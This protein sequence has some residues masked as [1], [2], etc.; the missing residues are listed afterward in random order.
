MNTHAARCIF[1]LASTSTVLVARSEP[2]PTPTQTRPSPSPA[3]PFNSLR[4][5]W[6][7]STFADARHFR[8]K[9]APSRCTSTPPCL[10]YPSLTIGLE[11]RVSDEHTLR[12]L[13]S[14]AKAANEKNDRVEMGKLAHEMGAIAY[15]RN[16]T[17]NAR[18]AHLEKFGCVEYTKES[19][20]VIKSYGKTRGVIEMGAGNGQWSRKLRE[21]GLDIVSF[22]NMSGLPL[23]L[24]LYHNR[25][26]PN[27]DFFDQQLRKADESILR[28]KVKLISISI[29]TN[30]NNKANTLTP[31]T[32]RTDGP[33]RQ[34]STTYIPR[35]I[36]NGHQHPKGVQRNGR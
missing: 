32:G 13:A 18:Q 27:S 12:S 19:L 22:D 26:K 16:V 15:G 14:Q 21:G 28:D 34:S 35:P 1:V 25:T 8:S 23:N 36:I 33:Q 20:D 17:P 10:S 6:V 24:N 30:N 31:P 5:A 7:S 2:A 9:T 4:A 3:G 11:K 29:H